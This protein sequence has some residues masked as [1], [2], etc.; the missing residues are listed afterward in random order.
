MNKYSSKHFWAKL[1]KSAKI[2]SLKVFFIQH[3]VKSKQ[4]QQQQQQQK[5]KI[6]KKKREINYTKLNHK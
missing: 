3:L 1:L 6:K 5:A 4:H 2:H